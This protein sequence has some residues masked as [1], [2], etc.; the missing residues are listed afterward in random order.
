MIEDILEKITKVH[1]EEKK[2]VLNRAIDFWIGDL[3]YFLRFKER[4]NVITPD[5]IVHYKGTGV[6]PFCKKSVIERE[7]CYAISY[8]RED[9]NALFHYLIN[10][11]SVRLKLALSGLIPKTEIE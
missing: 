10:H 8:A 5:L 6:C 11:P 2:A 7:P 9:S 1:F 3:E 4:K